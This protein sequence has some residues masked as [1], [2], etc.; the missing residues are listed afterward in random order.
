MGDESG[1]PT[2]L[3]GT[4]ERIG[5]LLDHTIVD[6]YAKLEQKGLICAEYVWIGGTGSD[7]RSKTKT[8]NKIPKSP[9]DLP[10]WNFDGSS[11][12]QAPGADSEVCLIPRRIF[13]DPFRGGD[14]IL[15]MSDC[16]E[17]PRQQDDGSISEYKAIP[18]NTRAPCAEAMKKAEKEE[19]WFGVEQEYTLLNSVTK[20]PLGWPSRGFPGPQGP[21]YCSAGTGASMGREIVEAHIKCCYFAGIKLSG[22]NAEVMPAQWEFQV[23]PCIGIDLGDEMWMARYILMRLAEQFN[24]DVTFD[25]KPIP[26]D[27]NGAGGHMNY[28]TNSTRKEGTGWD[29]IQEQIKKLEKKHAV[30]LAG[31][32]TGNERRLTGKHETSS[33]HEFTWGVANRGASVRVGRSV[34]VEKCGYYEDRRPSSNL[35][36]YVVTRLLVETTL[37]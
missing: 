29:A 35:D 16:Y 25:P 2:T 36:P 14:N 9:E 27:W 3:F 23:G 17:P 22:V 26:G 6:K 10:V 8:L 19:P 4:D 1:A 18:T 13:S 11:T 32:G 24:I 31:Y 33:M 37:L 5:A 15:V 20:W 30:H 28:S 7:L 21:Y 34:P 12:G